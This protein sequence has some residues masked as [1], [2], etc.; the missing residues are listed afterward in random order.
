MLITI[1]TKEDSKE[2]LRRVIELLTALLNEPSAGGQGTEFAPTLPE[3]GLSW[4]D[5]P[6]SK[7][8]QKKEEQLEL[9]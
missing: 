4:F 7:T 5:S 8:E 1:N 3:G 6:V 9:Y 2:E